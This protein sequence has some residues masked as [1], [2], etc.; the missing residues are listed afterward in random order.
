MRNIHILADLATVLH[1]HKWLFSVPP[2]TVMRPPFGVMMLRH[3]WLHRRPTG[4]RPAHEELTTVRYPTQRRIIADIVR[5]H[6]DVDCLH[7]LPWPRV[8][9]TVSVNAVDN[10]TLLSVARGL[11]MGVFG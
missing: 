9:I 1:R 8:F 2:Q 4:S 10:L 7:I 6:L 5:T 3:R 11:R